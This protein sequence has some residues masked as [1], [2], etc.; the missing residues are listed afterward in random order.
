MNV[1]VLKESEGVSAPAPVAAAGTYEVALGYLRAFITMLVVL[2]HSVLAYLGNPVPAQFAGGDMAWRA[3][4]VTDPAHPW[5]LTGIISGFNDVYFMALMFL[6]SGLFV[7]QSID[8]KGVVA[9]LRDRV[10]RLGIPF[11]FSAMIVTPIAYYFAYLQIGGAPGLANYW[12]A[13]QQ[14]GYWPTGPAWF[15]SL[16][17]AFDVVAAAVFTV[18]PRWGHWIGRLNANAAQKPFRFFLLFVVLSFAT[19]AP[20]AHLY[21]AQVWTYWGMFQFQ[22]A[23][24]FNYFLYFVIGVGLGAYGIRRGLLAPDGNLAKRWWVWAFIATPII[25][26]VGLGLF[27]TILGTK[28][29]ATRQML[30]E[31]GSVT[32]VLNCAIVSF[33]WLAV[34]TRFVKRANRLMDSLTANA[35]GIYIVHY[36]F[37]AGLQFALLPQNISG[38]GKAMIVTF[39]ALVLSWMTAMILRRVPVASKLMGE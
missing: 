30:V 25:F 27:L 3:F 15:I 11:L 31:I 35:Y 26:V 10:L 21:G 39:G 7:Q 32:F 22:S 23:R 12:A 20:L 33:M 19:Y 37:V 13:F 28:D 6:L 4:P 14:I 5:A 8:K 34:F 17:L 24:P 29:A 36:A 38:A 16:L 1:A 18:L 2:H 9:F